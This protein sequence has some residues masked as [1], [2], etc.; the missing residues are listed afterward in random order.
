M[1]KIGKLLTRDKLEVVPVP[2]ILHLKVHLP[3]VVLGNI[4]NRH[5]LLLK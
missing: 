1:E 5:K 2:I 3:V 4:L